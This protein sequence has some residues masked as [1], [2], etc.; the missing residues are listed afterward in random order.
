ML[1]AAMTTKMITKAINN[2][3]RP[4]ALNLFLF[5]VDSSCSFRPVPKIRFEFS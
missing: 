4:S 3:P 2:A 5:E 1:Q